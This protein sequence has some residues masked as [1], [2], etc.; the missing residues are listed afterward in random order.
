MKS[1]KETIDS[2]QIRLR[3][4]VRSAVTKEDFDVVIPIMRK[5]LFLLETSS[6]KNR[7]FRIYLMDPIED[8]LPRNIMLANKKILLLDD[9][10]RTGGTI[11]RAKKSIIANNKATEEGIRVGVF[12]KHKDCKAKIDYP[13]VVFDDTNGTELYGQLSDFF[14]S[15]CH[16]LDPDHM[17]IC[18]KM[19]GE[20][21]TIDGAH[22]LTCI[23]KELEQLGSYYPL[24]E[25]VCSLWGR[26]KFGVADLYACDYGLD[27]FKRYWKKEGVFK[28]RFCLEPNWTMYIVPI[29]CPE[30]VPPKFRDGSECGA[31]VDFK[32][33]RWSESLDEILCRDCI[34]YGLTK[35]FAD[36]FVPTFESGL[37]A[38]GYSYEISETTWP[39]IQLKYETFE[40]KI[41]ADLA[42]SRLRT[43]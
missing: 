31:P 36:K 5:G 17:I 34:S 9:S 43:N 16:Q 10:A 24:E 21:Q 15:M 40:H 37:Q 29:F 22:L 7:R 4:F 26:T 12:M 39:E 8:K 38:Q 28:V 35:A 42:N 3:N 20:S 18:E 32:F 30:I 33:C 1:R 23:R 6:P 11:E 41:L 13:E 19:K 2:L 25:S 14:D 27:A